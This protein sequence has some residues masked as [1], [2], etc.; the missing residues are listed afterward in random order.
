MRLIHSMASEPDELEEAPT[1]L[2]SPLDLSLSMSSQSLQ[3]TSV[4]GSYNRQSSVDV[5]SVSWSV[6]IHL[7]CSVVVAH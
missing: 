6:F 7:V 1:N 4:L 5:A 2:K 3:Q